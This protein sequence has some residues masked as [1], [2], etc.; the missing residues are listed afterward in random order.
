M[1]PNEAGRDAP[2]ECYPQ[3]LLP[4]ADENLTG[5]EA[6][7]EMCDPEVERSHVQAKC[8]IICEPLLQLVNNPQGMDR[9]LVV[10]VRFFHRR[11]S[12]G[13]EGSEESLNVRGENNSAHKRL[14]RREAGRNITQ[15]L[16]SRG[17]EVV[18][19]GPNRI[20]VDN[21]CCTPM[22][23][24]G[25]VVFD[26]I[27]ADRDDHVRGCKKLIAWCIVQLPY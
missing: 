27:I 6:V 4:I 1:W 7:E 22:I 2:W 21:L 12:V 26:G 14:E 15:D 13:R 24:D 23:P 10:V 11:R 5:S 18:N 17:V 3:C 9:V 16:H 19:V 8:H 25:R 20:N